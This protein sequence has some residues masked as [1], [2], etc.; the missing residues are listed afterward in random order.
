MKPWN[1]VISSFCSQ[2]NLE[3]RKKKVKTILKKE[4]DSGAIRHDF[5]YRLN[6]SYVI[7]DK[8]I[9]Y[10]YDPWLR[11]FSKI[12]I[13]CLTWNFEY[14]RRSKNVIYFCDTF[15]YSTNILEQPILCHRKCIS[16]PRP[17]YAAVMKTSRKN[18]SCLNTT[19]VSF[20]Y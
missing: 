12:M 17:H 7:L 20:F 4:Y 5:K 3:E 18:L 9:I 13:R 10:L 19:K 16:Q 1:K 15:I 11:G 2:Y 14:S 8:E 6:F